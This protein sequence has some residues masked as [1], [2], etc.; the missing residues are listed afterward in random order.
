MIVVLKSEN[1]PVIAPWQIETNIYRLH[2]QKTGS[3]KY[4]CKISSQTAAAHP[5]ASI[6]A[7]KAPSLF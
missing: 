7:C 5:D 4:L 3:T 1:N 6:G 2:I